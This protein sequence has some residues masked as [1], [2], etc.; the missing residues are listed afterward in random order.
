MGPSLSGLLVGNISTFSNDL[1]INLQQISSCKQNIL[2]SAIGHHLLFKLH[3]NL[4]VFP[5]ESLE[6]ASSCQGKLA[7]LMLK[8]NILEEFFLP[9]KTEM[10]DFLKNAF[11]ILENEQVARM[12]LSTL[13]SLTNRLPWGLEEF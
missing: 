13:E 2:T 4:A 9:K 5:N 11:P 7:S 6:W 8:L 10:K 3:I 12:P 1:T